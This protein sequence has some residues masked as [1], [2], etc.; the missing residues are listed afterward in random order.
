MIRLILGG[1][2]GE[3]W[4]RVGNLVR[5]CFGLWVGREEVEGLRGVSPAR[6]HLRVE[7]RIGVVV[8]GRI[9]GLRLRSIQ[10]LTGDEYDS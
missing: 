2:R 7:G 8:L 10:V 6:R 9:E 5:D 3:P 1:D 4:D